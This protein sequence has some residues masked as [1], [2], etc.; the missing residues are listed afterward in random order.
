MQPF[1]SWL[2]GPRARLLNALQYFIERQHN[3]QHPIVFEGQIVAPEEEENFDLDISTDI[4]KHATSMDHRYRQIANTI[5]SMKK[6][7]E[8]N[9]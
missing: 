3:Y 1:E 4:K 2:L 7:F 6:T 9:L 5:N 8:I